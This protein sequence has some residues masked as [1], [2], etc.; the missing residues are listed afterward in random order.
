[1]TTTND[2]LN[3]SIDIQILQIILT[4]LVTVPEDVKIQREIDELGV[5]ISVTV[6]SQDMGIVI[7]RSG[8]MANALKTLI[9]AVGK[10][11]KMNVRVHFLEADGSYR[12]ENTFIASNISVEKETKTQ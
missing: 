7:G 1:M 11:H 8:G 3:S 6:N 5:L 2:S 4:N 10:A 12:Y 9:K